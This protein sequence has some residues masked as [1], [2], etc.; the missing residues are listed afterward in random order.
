MPSQNQ[1]PAPSVS[2]PLPRPIKILF[3]AANPTDTTQLRLGQEVREIDDALRRAQYRDR[4]DLEQHHAV[5][6][7][8]LQGLLQRYRPDIVHFSGH[9]STTGEILLEDATGT[10]HPVTPRALSSTFSLLKDNIRC[11][12]LNACFSRIQA[13]AIAQHIDC[14]IGMSTA[15]TDAAAISFA[16]AFYQAVGYGQPLKTAFGLGLARID[17]E[18]LEE[19]DTPQLIALHVDPSQVTFISPQGGAHP[20]G[21]RQHRRKAVLPLRSA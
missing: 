9:G 3:L 5:Q 13:E 6:V 2:V 7:G 14:V 12:V 10:R 16:S 20:N 15:I 4:F 17:L 8:D 19:Q 21:E 11:V 1:P 18:N